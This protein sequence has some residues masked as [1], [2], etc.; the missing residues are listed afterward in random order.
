MKP[1]GPSI[2]TVDLNWAVWLARGPLAIF[3]DICLL[4]IGGGEATGI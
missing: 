4:Q 3:G 2:V 1:S